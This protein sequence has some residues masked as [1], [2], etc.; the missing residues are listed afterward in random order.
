MRR[1]FVLASA[2]ALILFAAESAR[3]APV[4][5]AFDGSPDAGTHIAFTDD[6]L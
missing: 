2:P 1:I 5:M 4:V 3:S 6:H